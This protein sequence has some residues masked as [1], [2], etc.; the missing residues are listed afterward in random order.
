VAQAATEHDIDLAFSALAEQRP[1]ALLVAPDPFFTVRRVQV[2]AAAAR[3][4]LPAMY[5]LRE[6]PTAGG[7]MSYGT[8]LADGYRKTG[9]Y[10]GKVLK[11]A[12]PAELPIEQ[13]TKFELV[14]NLKT[15][16]TLGITVPQTLL[17]AADEVIE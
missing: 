10:A 2:V 9:I 12:K 7:L 1:G 11:G 14:I 17:V 6:F 15:A 5:E 8:S 3:H 16:R 4:R 13:S